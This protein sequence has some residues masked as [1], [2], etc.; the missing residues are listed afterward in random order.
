[1]S[2]TSCASFSAELS[3]GVKVWLAAT[4]ATGFCIGVS[5]GIVSASIGGGEAGSEDSAGCKKVSELTRVEGGSG[6]TESAEKLPS[7]AK[8]EERE[9]SSAIVL[10]VPGCKGTKP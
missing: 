6:V 1:M 10:S 5:K 7:S 8:A 3:T 9:G 2:G 4:T